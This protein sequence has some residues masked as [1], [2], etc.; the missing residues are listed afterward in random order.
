M[1]ELFQNNKFMRAVTVLLFAG[2]IYLL[3]LFV[4]SVKAWSYIGLD[5]PPPPTISVTGDGEAFAV[6]DIAEFSFSVVKEA[7]TVP[8]AQKQ[9]SELSHA[10]IEFLQSSGVDEK[11]IKTVNYSVNPKY[12]WQ[13]MSK[14]VVCVR[15]PCPPIVEGKQVLTG[16]EVNQTV[17][18]KVRKVD[19]AGTLLSGVGEKGATNVSGV[20]FTID[21]P[22]AIQR[23]ARNIAIE[24]A[25]EKAAELAKDLDVRL[26]RI[27]AFNES[28]APG[29]IFF[30]KAMMAEGMGGD[31]MA[32]APN[33]TPGENKVTSNVTLT[34]EIR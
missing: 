21:N 23:E 6:P 15:A 26:V 22:D 4:N 10:I 19:T 13:Q 14:Q 16:Y 12:E 7:K 31:S 28:G 17:S 2:T 27:V 29:P 33:I 34:Y 20:E 32:L 24:K 8:E 30:G 18:V 11:D 25:K 1:H 9:S 5:A 3:A